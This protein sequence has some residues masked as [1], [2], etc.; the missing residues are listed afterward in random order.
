MRILG[1]DLGLRRIGVAL[2]DGQVV[3]SQETIEYWSRDEAIQRILKICREETIEKII[4][5]LPKS[6]SG[7]NEDMVRSFALEIN[8]LIPLP[9]EFVDE[10]L[11]SKEAER[12]LSGMKINPK[13]DKY[14]REIDRIS[15][16]L[17]L[18]QYLNQ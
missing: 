3:A 17:I 11:T 15:A 6:R 10:T 18:E 13:T 2:S 9:I 7:E 5:G 1:L 8:K 14:K 4:L 12:S 16:K